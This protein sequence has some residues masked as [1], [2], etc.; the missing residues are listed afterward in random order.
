MTIKIHNWENNLLNLMISRDS[1]PFEWGMHDCMTVSSDAVEAMT[2]MDPMKWA[3]G[4]Y[5]TKQEAIDIVTNHFGLSFIDTFSQ[6][7]N[8][9]GFKETDS[10][11]LG[12]ISFIKT[13]NLD[14]EASELFGGVTLATCFDPVG[15]M[16]VPGRD[17]LLLILKYELVKSWKL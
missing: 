8:D 12:D 7:F 1:V 9:L 11:G 2:C 15:N 10:V 17:G 13:E 16:I 3:R 4:K 5:K 6:I 14:P